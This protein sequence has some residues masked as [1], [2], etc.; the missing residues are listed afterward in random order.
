MPGTLTWSIP[1]P[2]VERKAGRWHLQLASV[3]LANRQ[4]K[5]TTLSMRKGRLI[6]RLMTALL[7]PRPTSSDRFH[8]YHF[9]V[10]EG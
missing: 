1:I 8:F 10:E 6:C 5:Q 2:A 3:D 7:P 9:L 4:S